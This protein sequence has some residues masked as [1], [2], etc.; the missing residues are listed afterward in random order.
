MISGTFVGIKTT[1][2]ALSLAVSCTKRKRNGHQAFSINLMTSLNKPQA[3][4]ARSVNR[5]S[6]KLFVD[7]RCNALR[8]DLDA[9]RWEIQAA[10]TF[11]AKKTS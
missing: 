6:A 1:Y 9:F 8:I 3:T 7:T 11:I 10:L 4:Y 5:L 2:P